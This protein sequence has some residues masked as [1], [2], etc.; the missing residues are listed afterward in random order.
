MDS[1]PTD[2]TSAAK[3]ALRASVLARRDALPAVERDTGS[4]TLTDIALAH[5][6]LADAE[7][8]LA[9]ASIGSEVRTIA[10]LEAVLRRGQRLVLPR[11]NRAL[12]RLDLYVVRDLECDLA[13]GT[14]DIP[15]PNP[16]RCEA[17]HTRE[18]IGAVV[19]PGAV[20]TPRCDRLGYGGGFYDRLL[21]NWPGAGCFIA[22]AFDV[23]IAEALPLGAHDIPMHEVITPTRRFRRVSQV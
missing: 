6:A 14:W 21:A 10:L 8:V 3:R 12:R 4:R 11:V 22:L 20:F 5:P 23:Q 7:G 15:E 1:G 19:V 18:P 2:P 17:L 9:Y 13:P 16:E